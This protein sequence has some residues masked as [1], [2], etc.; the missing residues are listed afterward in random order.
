MGITLVSNTTVSGNLAGSGA[1]GVVDGAPGD[2]AALLSIQTLGALLPQ[3]LDNK[4]GMAGWPGEIRE[5]FDGASAADT[6]G[7]TNTTDP[8]ILAAMLGM[9]PVTPSPASISLPDAPGRTRGANDLTAP[10]D[11]PDNLL[12]GERRP[13]EMIKAE[14][15]AVGTP[16]L[17]L[18]GGDPR[19]ET[20]NIAGDLLPNT[21]PS[22]NFGAAMSDAVSQRNA[23][24]ARQPAI[25]AP[26]HS[27]VWPEQ[28]GEKIVWI[29]RSD[30]Q[31]AQIN[32]NPPQMGPLQITLQLSG[33]QANAI[34]ASPHPEVRQAIE[35]AMPLLREMLQSAGINLGDASV[36]ANLAQQNQNNP[37]SSSNKNQSGHENAILPANG[38]PANTGIGQTE[39]RGNGLVD[40]FA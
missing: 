6:G 17:A 33:D 15:I 36:G 24:E 22:S 31:S 30:Q 25:S 37:F 4:D 20:A 40:L 5:V 7:T 39:H 21:G 29:A 32:I 16:R 2:F 34:F 13:Q 28:L 19:S 1:P 10:S 38:D 14:S 9:P 12:I 3:K 27:K 35:A 11:S 8:A 23:T 18:Q 26:L